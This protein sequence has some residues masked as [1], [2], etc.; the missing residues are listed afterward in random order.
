MIKK[1][2]DIVINILLLLGL[3]IIIVG[4]IFDIYKTIKITNK[5]ENPALCIEINDEYYC[6]VS[7][8]QRTTKIIE[9]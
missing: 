1:S 4:I 2:L 5:I 6:K 9:A 3:I 8:H 7:E